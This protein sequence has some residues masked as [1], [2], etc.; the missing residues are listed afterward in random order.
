MFSSV[1]PYTIRV[2]LH[3]F[4]SLFVFRNKEICRSSCNLAPDSIPTFGVWA[5]LC[6]TDSWYRSGN[7]NQHYKISTLTLTPYT[8]RE[9]LPINGIQHDFVCQIWLL[10]RLFI[11]L[12]KFKPG[13]TV[14]TQCCKQRKL[15]PGYT[16]FTQCC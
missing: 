2:F 15:K 13:Y 3:H 16:F 1:A 7:R 8:Q 14:C 12:R 9:T 5:V 10:N 4:A 6:E 11:H